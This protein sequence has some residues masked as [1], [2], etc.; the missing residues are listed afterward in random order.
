[1]QAKVW[2]FEAAMEAG[3][4]Q[5]ATAGLL[6]VCQK[7]DRRTRV[8]LEATALLA[9]CYL[10]QKNLNA[11]EPLIGRVLNSHN[12]RSE[13][14]KKIF[15]RL[16][17]RRFEAEGLLA[18]L[19]THIHEP[20]DPDAINNEA[21][22]LVQTRTEDEIYA[23]MGSVLPRD[24]VDFL[25]KIDAAAKRQLTPSEVRFLPS[26]GDIVERSELGRTFFESTKLVLWRSICDRSSEIYKAW[27]S[28]GFTVVLNKKYFAIAISTMLVDLGIGIKALAVSLAAIV[29]KLGL[30]VYC[31]TCRP[32]SVLSARG[33]GQ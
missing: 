29:M 12:I 27:F 15:L 31:E 6:G 23:E 24:A 26:G 5:V 14:R 4:L 32:R 7:T 2:L 22:A 13:N 3:N 33:S 1:M 19:R 16:I 20:M 28:E 21:G 30:E 9:I 18:A 17:V 25:L 10:R 8:H 11:A